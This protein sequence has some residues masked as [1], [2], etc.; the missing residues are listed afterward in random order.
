MFSKDHPG[1]ENELSRANVEAGRP[2]EGYHSGPGEAVWLGL[3]VGVGEGAAVEMETSKEIQ[4][5]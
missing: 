4:N 5:Q 2:W 3:E 1:A